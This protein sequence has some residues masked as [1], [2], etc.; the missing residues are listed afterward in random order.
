M[1]TRSMNRI[2]NVPHTNGNGK[3]EAP[4]RDIDVETP[5]TRTDF[6]RIAK[7][8]SIQFGDKTLEADP[9]T[10]TTSSS[11]WY[12]NGKSE[13]TLADGRKVRVQVGCNIIVIGSK[14]WMIG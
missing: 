6:L 7:A 10:F 12:V 11:G 9:R 8:L 5:L 13:V 14:E 1:A 4:K 3:H 2:K